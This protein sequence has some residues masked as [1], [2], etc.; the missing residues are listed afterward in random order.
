[1]RSR[2]LVVVLALILATLATVGVFL[3]SRGVKEDALEG[4]DVVEVV[5]SEVDI[6]ANT[7][8]NQLIEEER[9]V[10]QQLPADAVVEDAVTEISQLQGR[11]NSVFILAGEQIP[12][13]RVEGGEVPG[14][15]IGI[16]D[17]HQAMTVALNAPRAVAGALAGGDNV[18]I[19]ATFEDIE[20]TLLQ[21]GRGQSL[22]KLIQTAVREQQRLQAAGQQ[23]QNVEIPKF[24]ATVVLVPEVE[25]LRVIRESQTSTG[26]PGEGQP[27]EEVEGAIS[28]TLAFLP[29]EAQ[30]FVFALEQGD[31]Y[32]SLLPPDQAGTEL[33][34]L[35][36]AQIIL[37]EKQK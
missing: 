10:L 11:R 30:Q 34:P 2:G 16:P 9:F 35:T 22:D 31:V 5:V 13:S 12:L 25:V 6:P 24:D 32:L 37:P 36:V 8:L 3:Y 29:E 28:V 4:G 23:A 26:V 1:M 18:T 19:Y 15:V 21:G 33:D 17:G 20:L 27:Q 14:G 7:D